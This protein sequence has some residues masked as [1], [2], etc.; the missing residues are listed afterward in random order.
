VNAGTVLSGGEIDTLV[1]LVESGPL[2]DGDVPSKASRDRLIER[3][4]ATRC[5]VR[6]EDGWQAATYRGRDAYK[7]HFGDADTLAEAKAN[8][9]ARRAINSASA[10]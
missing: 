7:A 8:R 4:F 10:P 9:I 6:G 3:G 1:A 2:W 5:V